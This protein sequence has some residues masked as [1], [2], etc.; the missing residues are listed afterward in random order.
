MGVINANN[1]LTFESTDKLFARVRK[2]LHSFDAAG[3]LDEGDFYFYVRD[4]VDKLGVSVY[5]EGRVLIN[6][7]HY[8]VALPDNFSYLYAAYL[9]SPI[10]TTSQSKQTCFPQEGFALY[11]EDTWQPYRQCKN[12]L[13]TK[14]EFNEGVALRSRTYVQGKPNTLN[15]TRPVLL[16][17]TANVKPFLMHDSLH[18]GNPDIVDPV[19]DIG[20][21]FGHLTPGLDEIT[22][23]NGFIHTT[24]EEG[25]IFMLYYGLALDPDTGLPM[26]PSNSFIEKALEDYIIYR[27]IEDIWFNGIVPDMDNRYKMAKANS[28]DSMKSAMYWCKLPSFQTAIN[29]IRIQRKNL[30]IYQQTN[31]NS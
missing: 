31:F 20:L 23:H 10:N 5:E 6:V 8:R 18:H 7:Q 21:G 27:I 26:I 28:D 25:H 3:I 14:F 15:Y 16:R 9:T 19:L 30:R 12:C 11:M 4:V 29:Y 13:A 2:R 22:I 17:V 24:F 1:M